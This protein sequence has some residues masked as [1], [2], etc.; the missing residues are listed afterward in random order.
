MGMLEIWHLGARFVEGSWVGSCQSWAIVL[1]RK[2]YVSNCML[3]WKLTVLLWAMKGAIFWSL[4][5]TFSFLW[6]SR[7]LN[8]WHWE[9]P[10]CPGALEP[11]VSLC[12]MPACLHQALFFHEVCRGLNK[13][14]CRCAT[15]TAWQAVCYCRFSGTLCLL[16]VSFFILRLQGI[17][18]R[19][20]HFALCF[21]F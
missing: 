6:S 14:G 21:A 19:I 3:C 18:G 15:C 9:S 1:P 12:R 13:A 10:C 2:G 16:I 7:E 4:C 5:W 8:V 17:Q 20:C 11:A